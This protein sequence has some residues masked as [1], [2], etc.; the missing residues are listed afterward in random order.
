MMLIALTNYLRPPRGVMDRSR[1]LERS[2][3]DDVVQGQ[4]KGMYLQL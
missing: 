2:I 3:L 1:V 4:V